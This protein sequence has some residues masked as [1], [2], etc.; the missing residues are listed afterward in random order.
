MTPEQ[1][2]K[3]S[4]KKVADAPNT[5]PV[6]AQKTPT[7]FTV[8]VEGVNEIAQCLNEVNLNKHLKQ[9]LFNALNEHLKPV[10]D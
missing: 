10:F 9:A 5:D 7:S 6:A 8:S 1:S 2:K 3:A 4:M